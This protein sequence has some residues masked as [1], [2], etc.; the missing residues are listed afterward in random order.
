MTEASAP[1]A[2]GHAGD[3]AEASLVGVHQLSGAPALAPLYARALATAYLPGRGSELP[4]GRLGLSGVAVDGDRL[5]DYDRVCGFRVSDELPAT[6]PHV[7]AF[8]LAMRIMTARAFPFAL[9]GLVHVANTI[10]QRRPLRTGE[11]LHLATWTADLREHPRGRQFDVVT[12]A[13]TKGEAVWSERSTYLHRGGGSGDGGSREGADGGAAPELSHAATWEVPGDIGRRYAAVS[14]DRNPIHLHALT[15]KAFGFPSA[16]A[17]GMW[18]QARCL[19]AFEGRLPA[20]FRVQTRFRAPLTI[21]ARADFQSAPDGR[22]GWV[23][24][25]RRPRD[26]RE[27]VTGAITALG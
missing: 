11:P 7:L 1:G 14:G 4:D 10:E 13:S 18:T 20:A 27:H 24:A 9:L 23:F 22:G 16:I 5:A 17:H 25:L 21:P 26:G 6:Y 8:P 12:W 19:A 15:A 3:Q 2:T